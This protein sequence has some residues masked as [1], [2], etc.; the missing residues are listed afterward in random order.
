[1]SHQTNHWPLEIRLNKAENQLEI[2][3][4]DGSCFALSA[5]LLRVE[6]PSA[7]VQGHHPDDKKIVSGRKHVAIL[8]IEAIGR[9]AIK[10]SFDD[11]HDTG[12]YSWD[13]LYRLGRDQDD[14]W[15][16]YIS[17]LK[18]QGLTRDP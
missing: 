16:Q 13:Y 6:S 7:E 4:E 11:L 5:E 10:I 8:N 9:Y 12:I 1:M 14:V 3:F 18:E 15:R 17:D 2:D